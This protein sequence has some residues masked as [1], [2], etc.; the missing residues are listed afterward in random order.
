MEGSMRINVFGTS[1]NTYTRRYL[2]YASPGNYTRFGN[3]TPLLPA[4]DDK[5]VVMDREEPHQI[6]NTCASCRGKKK[7]TLFYGNGYQ[8][9]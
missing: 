8:S 2:P 5:F 7:T 1:P 6:H 4:V 9:I 3:I